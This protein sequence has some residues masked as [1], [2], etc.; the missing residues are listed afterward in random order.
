MWNDRDDR[1]SAN[2][3]VQ[4]TTKYTYGL[5]ESLVTWE[6]VYVNGTVVKV[7]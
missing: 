6:K 3:T 2:K 7:Y 1:T 4:A 5:K